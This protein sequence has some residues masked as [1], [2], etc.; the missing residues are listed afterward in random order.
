MHW[1]LYQLL[2]QCKLTARG[3]ELCVREVVKAFAC[4]DNRLQEPLLL[5]VGDALE[6]RALTSSAVWKT[7]GSK[8]LMAALM[9]RQGHL[10]KNVYNLQFDN[11]WREGV[12]KR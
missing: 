12:D 5:L 7:A 4:A 6:N 9:L 8:A 2:H 1:L 10:Q 3:H 11:L